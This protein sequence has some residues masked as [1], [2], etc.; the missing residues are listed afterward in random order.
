ML[1]EVAVSRETSVMLDRHAAALRR[2]NDAI[3]LVSR[4]RIEDVLA[5]ARNEATLIAAAAEGLVGHWVDLGSGGGFPGVPIAIVRRDRSDPV[6]LVDS[7]QRK[8][9]FLRSV[10]R[11]LGLCTNVVSDRIERAEPLRASIL[12]AKALAPLPH[13]LGYAERHLVP[14]GT[15]FFPK[16]P[17]YREEVIGA[18]RTWGFDLDV[19]DGPAG[20]TSVILRIEGLRR[21]A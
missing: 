12:S 7:D 20:R 4:D 19:L 21:A 18:R 10:I 2:W 16:G 14:G 5:V 6:T 17:R 9:A 3:N 15:A 13:L 8:C 1:A 11:D